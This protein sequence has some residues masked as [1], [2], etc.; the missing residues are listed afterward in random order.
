MATVIDFEKLARD[1]ATARDLLRDRVQAL[2]SLIMEMKKKALPGIRTAAERAAEKQLILKGEIQVN[3]EMFVKPR[4]MIL[5][6]IRFGF[7]KGKGKICW[8]DE[9]QVIKL[10]KKNFPDY[11]ETLIEVKECPRKTALADL[12]AADLKKIGVTIIETGDEVFIKF[13]DSEID[14]IVNAILKETDAG[15]G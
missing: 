10:I 7:Q 6:G 1:L 4:T 9:E 5:H 13:T 3:P 11:V 8:E 2:E 15:E 12:S 14:R